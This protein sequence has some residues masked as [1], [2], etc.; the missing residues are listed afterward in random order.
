[1][2][3]GFKPAGIIVALLTPFADDEAVDEERLTSH[4]DFLVEA[5]VQGVMPIG[6]SGEYA[7]LSAAERMRVVEVTVR[8]VGGR[9]PVTVGAL[10]PS[11]REAVEVG[12]H[13]ASVGADALLVLPPYYIAPS[14]AGVVDHYAAVTERTGLPVVVYNNPGRTARP[15]DVELLSELADL[16]GTIAVK[17]CDRD[18]GTISAKI[19]AIRGRMSYLCGDDDLVFPSLISGADGAIMALPNLAPRLCAS[20]FEAHK[21]SDNARALDLHEAIVRLVRVRRI[22]NHPGPLK[23]ALSMAGRPVGLGRRPLMPMTPGEREAVAAV[24]EQLRDYI[25]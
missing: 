1:M 16:P 25:D 17:D 11:T 15:I 18:L 12:E 23:E 3:N 24:S 14:A 20:L 5:G 10:S 7:N 9:V 21:S 8:A 22:P 6:G 19:Q 2:R 4:V 13:A